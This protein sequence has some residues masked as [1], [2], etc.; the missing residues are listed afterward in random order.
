MWRLK[1][2]IPKEQA[3]LEGKTVEVGS[4]RLQIRSTIAEGGFSCVYLARDAQSGKQFAL[5]HIVCNDTESLD[6]VKKEVNALKVLRG[7][8]SII[9]LHAQAMYDMGRTKE[10]FIVTDYCEKMMVEVLDSRGAG[11]FEEKQLLLMFRDICNAVY[12]M[13]CLS[14]PMAH[15]DLKAENLLLGSDGQWKLCDFGSISVNHKRFEKAAE[16]GIEEDIIRKHTTPAYRAPEMWDLYRRDLINEKVDIWALGCL[17]FRMAYL[18]SA[19]DGDSKLQILNG[20]YRIPDQPKYSANITDLI[21]E[22]LNSNPEERPSAMQV[23]QRVNSALP[24]ECQKI[25]PDNAPSSA[26][27]QDNAVQGRLT[28]VVPTRTPPPPPQ[29]STEQG[30]PSPTQKKIERKSSPLASGETN[31]SRVSGSIK[32]GSVG[33]FWSTQHAQEA[34]N[35]DSKSSSPQSD[36]TGL[37]RQH[38]SISTSPPQLGA[39]RA[40]SNCSASEP[41][42]MR[43][44]FPKS[45]GAEGGRH[46]T[47]P[48][49][50]ENGNGSD[51]R[52]KRG[53]KAGPPQ[54][55]RA[56]SVNQTSEDAFN[57]FVADFQKASIF[58]VDSVHTRDKGQQ[59]LESLRNELKQAKREK[60]EFVAKYEELAAMCRSQRLEIQELKAALMTTNSGASSK[61]S[62]AQSEPP[63]L[64]SKME[65]D[66]QV[67][68]IWD[69]QQG[70][71][72]PGK[73]LESQ[74]WKAFDDRPSKQMPSARN[75]HQDGGRSD[76]FGSTRFEAGKSEASKMG[77]SFESSQ[78]S[79]SSGETWGLHDSFSTL[80]TGFT[81]VRGAGQGFQSEGAIGNSNAHNRN[82]GASRPATTT[83]S[84]QPSG[85]SN[86]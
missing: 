63:L 19:F 84:N 61:G 35:E 44:N 48:E 27:P 29:R 32:G 9:T 2:L 59:E 67:S 77:A 3:G 15:R 31:S 57:E 6:L 70:F 33:S 53:S 52:G 18:K 73:S 50:D 8:P 60:D 41:R 85:W 4:L 64:S 1:Q 14:P 83:Q 12:A 37:S 72:P 51:V 46:Y 5:K 76:T 39:Q 55:G 7:H 62:G 34:F 71:S 43:S 74:G 65:L 54:T 13:H 16:M 68:T 47:R 30:S 17:L 80:G 25:S 10:C 45:Q 22:M 58:T 24:V 42:S 82:R 56:E 81:A 69:L 78:K 23:W 26:T 28:S 66:S 49:E 86:F 79:R 36:S 11:F 20:N 21:K 40:T 38:G 75:F